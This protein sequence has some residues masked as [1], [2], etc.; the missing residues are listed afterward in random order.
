LKVMVIGTSN[1]SGKTT[2]ICICS[3]YLKGK[4][5]QMVPFKPVMDNRSHEVTVLS[6]ACEV[7]DCS[8][9]SIES[10][11]WDSNKDRILECLDGISDRHLIC[12][13]GLPT[14]FDIHD[15]DGISLNL[16]RMFKMPIILVADISRGGMFAAIH[17]TWQ[18]IPEDIRPLMKGYVITQFRGDPASLW[19]GVD[20][21][22]DMTGLEC[23]GIVPWDKDSFANGNVFKNVNGIGK[24][25]EDFVKYDL[26]DGVDFNRMLN[27]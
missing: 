1:G 24:C 13:G 23:Y 7:N 27:I 16:I 15:R 26:K 8:F 18:L 22:R 6:K 14:D 5:I 4:G 21:I 25:V 19:S 20:I 3:G 10:N 17:G 11:D 9:P 2:F 12:E